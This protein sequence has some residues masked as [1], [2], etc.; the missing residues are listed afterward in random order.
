MAWTTFAWCATAQTR[1]GYSGSVAYL[2]AIDRIKVSSAHSTA[3]VRTCPSRALY[4]STRLVPFASVNSASAGRLSIEA[5]NQRVRNLR[6]KILG[7]SSALSDRNRSR[8]GREW[9]R[10]GHC[11]PLLST[12]GFR[13]LSAK[14][15]YSLAGHSAAQTATCTAPACLFEMSSVTLTCPRSPQP[16]PTGP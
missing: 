4:F 6:S 10:C 14:P 11:S 15:G 1:F 16:L 13:S 12:R 2:P 9:E 3:R 8:K 7:E 5:L